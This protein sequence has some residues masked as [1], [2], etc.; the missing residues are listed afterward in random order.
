MP[1][2]VLVAAC[3]FLVESSERPGKVVWLFPMLQMQGLAQVHTAEAP[4]P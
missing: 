3:H 1:G 4:F 2:V